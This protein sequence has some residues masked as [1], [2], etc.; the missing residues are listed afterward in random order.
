[1]RAGTARVKP[2]PGWEGVGPGTRC[3]IVRVHHPALEN[4]IGKVIV[5]TEVH[6]ETQ[7]VWGHLDEPVR[8]RGNRL[9][10]RVVDYD[11]RQILG[12]YGMGLLEVP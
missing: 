2:L 5:V 4:D 11:P 1:M 12:V 6:H 3:R 9:G 8:Y 10:R 7:Q